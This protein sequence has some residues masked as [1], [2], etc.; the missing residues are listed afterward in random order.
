MTRESMSYGLFK[1]LFTN[2]LILEFNLKCLNFMVYFLLL[3]LF[4]ALVL[5]YMHMTQVLWIL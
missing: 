4:Y 3:L 5:I 2:F 1:T